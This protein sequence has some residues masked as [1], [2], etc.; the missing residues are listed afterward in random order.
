MKPQPKA[1]IIIHNH[2]EG[3]F[4]LIRFTALPNLIEEFRDFGQIHTN[5]FGKYELTV[6]E[7]YDFNE[8]LEYM[9]SL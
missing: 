3:D 1:K 7:L 4:R 9:T 5:E 2:F 8:V 6:S